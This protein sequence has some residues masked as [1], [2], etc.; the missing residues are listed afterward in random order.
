MLLTD[1][2]AALEA[3]EADF[4]AKG[5]ARTLYARH[6]SE[7]VCWEAVRLSPLAQG[8]L[9]SLRSK[10]DEF[11]GSSAATL[12]FSL[13]Q[14]FDTTGE[15]RRYEDAYFAHRARLNTFALL[16]L[17]GE[18][19]A[20]AQLEDAIWAICDEYTWCLPA[21]LGG[22]SLLP[23]AVPGGAS[24]G[25]DALVPQGAS[26]SSVRRDAAG[27]PFRVHDQEVDLFAAETASALAEICALL[28]DRLNPVVLAR[29]R[30]L[31]FQRVLNPVQQAGPAF[32]WETLP[33]NW[34]AVC[35]GAVGMAAMYLISDSRI[36]APVLMRCLDAMEV[37]LSGYAR[38][39]A[40]TEGLGY[41]NYGFGYFICFA[42][43]L[44]V[45]TGGRMDLTDAP[46]IQEIALFQQRVWLGD[47]RVVSFSDGS[48]TGSWQPGLTHWLQR[49]FPG[50]MAPDARHVQRFGDDRC[51]RWVMDVRNFIWAESSPRSHAAMVS[52]SI[53]F[54][55]AAWLIARSASPI[56]ATVFAAKGGHNGE[57]HN[58]NDLGTFLLYAGG[59]T[60]LADTGSG[61]YT[62]GYF[63]PERY[64]CL[65]NSSFG[66]SVP[67]IGNEG[68]QAGRSF[69]ADVIQRVMDERQTILAL[70]LTGAY[71]LPRLKSL[72]RTFQW[73]PQGM[74]VLTLEDHVV[75]DG[76]AEVVTER[77]V[78]Y[79]KPVCAEDGVRLHGPAGTLRIRSD[80]LHFRPVI[81]HEAYKA[82]N[83]ATEVLWM[84]EFQQSE[85][86]ADCLFR[87]VFEW[88]EA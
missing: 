84:V 42:E 44:L 8:S 37:F 47:D 17:S 20:L 59:E 76:E 75:Q 29:A 11:T 38:D 87:A 18:E 53:W 30:A 57:P 58:H 73:N 5:F 16:A 81:R 15:R 40:C 34:A 26:L 1:L 60:Y 41:W 13:F 66:H 3:E 6:A 62:K 70:D 65:V 79:L 24:D 74:P 4:S 52:D 31:V 32:V 83:G 61:E 33:N 78:T 86:A 43:R 80:T 82:H 49:R 27:K 55:D 2:V 14:L 54:D 39:G 36:L 50:V 35:G 28:E 23:E 67:Q 64:A 10:R 25:F 68:Q 63:G 46:Q 56:G 9:G 85:P 22:R 48:R 69:H 21:H 7:S 45:R 88:L 77:F 51:H 72:T 12:P 19:T 71:D